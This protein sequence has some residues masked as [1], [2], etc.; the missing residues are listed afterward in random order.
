MTYGTSILS[1][2]LENYRPQLTDN[3]FGDRPLSAW[4]MSKKRTRMLSGGS[5][6][7]EPMIIAGGQAGSYGGYEQLAITPQEGITEA[8]YPW[9][10]LY[11]S[12]AISGLEEAQNNG[13]EA[14]INLLEAKIM[15]AE[16]TLKEAVNVQLFGDGT[17]NSNKV[18]LGLDALIGGV[19]TDDADIGVTTVGTI[20]RSF[21]TEGAGAAASGGA[22][23]GF[24]WRSVIA[25][26]TATATELSLAALTTPYNSASKGNDRPDVLFTTQALFE[27]YEALLLPSVRR[28]HKS[29]ADA[30]FENLMFRGVPVFY[31]ADCTAGEIY[32]INSKYLTLVGHKDRWFKNSGFS[33][34]MASGHATSGASVVTD[35]RQAIITAYGNLTMRNAARHFRC[36]N[37]AAAA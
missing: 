34:N 28:S 7:R 35:S 1:T 24:Y 15:Q 17:A 14:F 13:K 27:A 18:W 23:T 26:T 16:E 32:G 29:S 20:D 8:V 37:F 31:D 9:K 4:L 6:I 22:D 36:T 30:G 25:G 2:T 3:V 21:S 12:I 19:D 10:Q 11:A 5:D 33:D